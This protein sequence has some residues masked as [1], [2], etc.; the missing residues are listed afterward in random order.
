MFHTVIYQFIK[1]VDVINWM[2]CIFVAASCANS[3]SVWK[4]SCYAGSSWTHAGAPCLGGA[5]QDAGANETDDAVE[6][7]AAAAATAK[8]VS[9]SVFALGTRT[10]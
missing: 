1:L 2:Y 9:D 7:S 5:A 10:S 8:A 4:A 3:A 6:S